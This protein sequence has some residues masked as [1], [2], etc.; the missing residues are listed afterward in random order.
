[1]TDALRRLI[2]GR[3]FSCTLRTVDDPEVP[4][5][6][7]RMDWDTVRRIITTTKRCGISRCATTSGRCRLGDGRD[8]YWA[9]QRSAQVG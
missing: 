5:V 3:R 7:G 2:V 8:E 9:T 1:M 6:H 4:N